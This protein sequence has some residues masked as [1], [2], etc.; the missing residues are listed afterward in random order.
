MLRQQLKAARFT[1]GALGLLIAQIVV[2]LGYLLCEEDL[3]AEIASW[4]RATP[5]NVFEH[6][7]VWTLVTGALL[8]PDM[9]QLVFAGLL[10]WM[11]V[12]SLER[13]WGTPRFFRFVA[14]TS[15]VGTVAGTLL[16]YARGLDVPIDG[17]QPFLWA[18]IVAYGV[19]NAR[20][21][22]TFSFYI[23]MTG[24]QMMWGMIAVLALF[25]LIQQF[26]ELGAAFAAAMI[27]A[28]VITSRKWSPGLAWKRWRIARARAK[29]AVLDG[30]K[31]PKRDDNKWL[32]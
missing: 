19:V 5:S 13:F 23:Q 16:G 10:L 22:V 25:V 32:N 28:V 14:I 7:R 3:R 30:G 17:L 15:L 1:P 21:R 8:Q 29:L 6:G 2:S 9:I 20:Q 24:R 31:K 11:F 18:S 12:P 27:A 26:W 4:I